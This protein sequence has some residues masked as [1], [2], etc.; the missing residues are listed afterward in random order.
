MDCWDTRRL[1]LEAHEAKQAQRPKT[2]KV[3]HSEQLRCPKA[4]V[5]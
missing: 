4:L 2:E 3:V 1:A 5:L